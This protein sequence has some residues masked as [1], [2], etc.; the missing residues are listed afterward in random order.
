MPKAILGLEESICQ[1]L[2]SDKLETWRLLPT[3]PN[4]AKDFAK[5]WVPG[6]AGAHKQLKIFISERLKSYAHGRD[7]PGSDSTSFLSSHLHF[8][9]ISPGFIWNEISQ[10]DDT[11]N[12]E[13]FLS[14]LIWREFFYHLLYHF[15]T[16][17]HENFKKE[18]NNFKWQFTEKNLKAWQK[19]QTG[20]PI[21]DAGMRQLWQTGYMHNRVRMIVASFLIKHLLIDWRIGQ[22]W[23]W[24]TLLDADLANNAS[25]WQWVAGSGVDASPYYRIFNPVLQG[26]KFDPEGEYVKKWVPELAKLSS[27]YLHKPWEASEQELRN[28]HIILNKTY[29]KPIIDLEV[30]RKKALENYRQL[31]RQM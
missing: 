14:E 27:K 7:F 9:E 20:Y 1:S 10:M 18:F 15:P 4:W 22:E 5:L 26:K 12:I 8:G 24:Q 11:K 25:N 2:S 16:L 29:P 17:P 19:G 23:F 31:K 30:G 6:E 28:A 3:S 21:V 13:K